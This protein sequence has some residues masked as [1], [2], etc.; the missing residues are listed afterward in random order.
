MSLRDVFEGIGTLWSWFIDLPLY[1]SIPLAFVAA[2]IV[3]I[4]VILIL[5][6]DS[7]SSA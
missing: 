3:L 6:S 2:W 5:A 4:G 7:D 1:F